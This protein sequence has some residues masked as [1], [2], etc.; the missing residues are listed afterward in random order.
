[1]RICI[2]TITG[3]KYELEVDPSQTILDIK[4]ILQN[5]YNFTGTISLIYQSKE[6]IDS[7]VIGSFEFSENSFIVLFTRKIPVKK[8]TVDSTKTNPLNVEK[9]DDNESTNKF[10]E[11]QTKPE[12]E[13]PIN[14]ERSDYI[15]SSPIKNLCF[16]AKTNFDDPPDFQ[17]KV[18]QLKILGYGDCDCENALRAAIYQVDLAADYLVSGQIP[19]IPKPLQLNED[20]VI[21]KSSFEEDFNEEEEN[22]EKEYLNDLILLKKVFQENPENFPEEVRQ[23]EE[24]DP[25][26]ARTIK[27]DPALFLYQLGLD[28]SKF[29]TEAVKRPSSKYE[30][31]MNQFNLEEK[32]A[33]HRIESNGFDTMTVIQVFIACDKNEE[34][35]TS[36]LVSMRT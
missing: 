33:I 27:R 30:E 35:T 20:L 23:L 1:M 2:K 17:D 16:T 3:K 13:Q 14:T 28:P 18:E 34:L 11:T 31:L 10:T 25:E 12:G 32:N 22:E 9:N 6:L 7:Q 8:N 19:D 21:P 5:D 36:C 15:R 29:D 26:M 4:S 24:S